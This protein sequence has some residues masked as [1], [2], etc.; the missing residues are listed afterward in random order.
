MVFDMIPKNVCSSSGRLYK[1]FHGILSCIYISSLVTSWQWLDCLYRCMIKYRKAAC[2]VFLMMNTQFFET[3]RRQYNWIKS[4]TKKG[5]RFVG[6]SYIW[7]LSSPT[8][9]DLVCLFLFLSR[10]SSTTYFF[11]YFILLAIRKIYSYSISYRLMCW[12]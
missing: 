11:Y 10:S 6:S 12:V 7:L 1:Q 9:L 2:T 5:V 8:K 3:C 4:L